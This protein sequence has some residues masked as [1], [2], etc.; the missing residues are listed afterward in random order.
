MQEHMADSEKLKTLESE[1]EALKLAKSSLSEEL[2]LLQDLR[3]SILGGIVAS[4][5]ELQVTHQQHAS[6]PTGYGTSTQHLANYPLSLHRA[7]IQDGSRK[8]CRPC[9]ERVQRRWHNTV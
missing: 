2:V 8:G 3:A 9:K 7:E 4:G 1:N 5:D 6:Q